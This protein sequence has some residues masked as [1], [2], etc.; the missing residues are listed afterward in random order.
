MVA[1]SAHDHSA[2][3]AHDRRGTSR[4]RLAV[5][6]VLAVLVLVGQLVGGL[7]SGSVAL[8]ADAAHVATDATGVGLALF[9]ATMAARPASLQRTFGWQRLEVLAAAVNAAALLA[10]GGWVLVE[11]VQRL[12]RPG[13]VQSGTML[14][15]ALAGAAANAVSL[16]VLSGADRTNL[17]VRGAYLEVVVD[18][19]GSAAVVV[20]AVVIRYTGFDRAD[21]VVAVV[22]AVAIVPRTLRLLREAVDVLLEATPRGVDLGDVRRHVLDTPGVLDVHDL[23][24]WTITSGMPVLSAHVVVAD[25]RL[26][27]TGEVLDA[28]STCLV[29]HFDVEHCTF[30]LEPAGH[31]PHEQHCAPAPERP[32]AS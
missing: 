9:A 10:V 12:D 21:A 24:A 15:V 19:L 31:Q 16:A 22:I 23:H 2:G 20:A 29:G 7:V 6:F 27:R 13:D 18:L 5:A 26:S 8:L 11:A 17:N 32:R 14:L 3:H 4:G 30:Q 1:V 25:D 28:L